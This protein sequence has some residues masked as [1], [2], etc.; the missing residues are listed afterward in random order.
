MK[1]LYVAY[2]SN[3]N[4]EQMKHRCPTAKVY[5]KGVLRDHKLF[6]KGMIHNAFLTIEPC[7]DGIVPVALWD[8][9][10]EDEKALDRYEGYPNV[11]YKEDVEVEL[12][13]GEIVKAMVYIMGMDIDYN[14][15]SK[16]YHQAVADGY[17]EFGFDTKYIEEAIEASINKKS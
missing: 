8:I 12:D 11:Y 9:K 17:Q 5:G 1:R 14:K 4:L 6:F 16:R 13:T 10:P 2:G 7:K 3:L 15:P